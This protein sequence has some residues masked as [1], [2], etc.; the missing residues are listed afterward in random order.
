MI[1]YILFFSF[2]F[3]FIY[4]LIHCRCLS[5][6]RVVLIKIL[7]WMSNWFWVWR[8]K[9]ARRRNGKMPTDVHMH[10]DKMQE[11]NAWKPNKFVMPNKWNVHKSTKFD[12]CANITNPKS[13]FNGNSFNISSHRMITDHLADGKKCEHPVCAALCCGVRHLAFSGGIS[14]RPIATTM[15]LRCFGPSSKL[16]C[17]TNTIECVWLLF[18]S[19]PLIV[20]QEWK[21]TPPHS[22]LKHNYYIH[23]QFIITR[24]S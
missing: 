9:A 10:E 6:S 12:V 5:C 3:Y 15:R 22:N 23:S 17:Q 20:S 13:I 21:K 1:L 19:Y 18:F 4:R 14:S 2:C 11:T 24:R 16:W 7:H 8:N